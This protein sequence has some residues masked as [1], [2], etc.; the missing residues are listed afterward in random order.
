MTV[1]RRKRK[2]LASR[3]ALAILAVSAFPTV[4]KSDAAG[5]TVHGRVLDE[6]GEPLPYVAILLDGSH[7]AMSDQQGRFRVDG[8]QDSTAELRFSMM[9]YEDTVVALDDYSPTEMLPAQ[10]RR[11]A[12]RDGLAAERQDVRLA[13]GAVAF[14]QKL[15]PT[16]VPPS[17]QTLVTVL[18]PQLFQGEHPA[19]V[20]LQAQVREATLTEVEMTGVGFYADFATPADVPLAVPPNFA[21]GDARIVLSGAQHGAGCVVFVR[22]GRLAIL[23]A[24]TFDDAWPLDAQVLEITHVFPVHPG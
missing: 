24:Y 9:A 13:G 15:G 6:A 11:Q 14:P 10:A 3:S 18:L 17:V 19:L 12:L 7:I 22:D 1:C 2:W 16:K 4:P 8:V 23:E 20:A 21:G 5:T